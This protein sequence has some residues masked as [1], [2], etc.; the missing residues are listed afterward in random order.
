MTPG[1]DAA[2]APCAMPQDCRICDHFRVVI[3][4]SN[5][6]CSTLCDPVTQKETQWLGASCVELRVGTSPT[7]GGGGR[8]A[9]V[10]RRGGGRGHGRSV[11][12]P[13]PPPPPQ[14]PCTT[15]ARVCGREAESVRTRAVHVPSFLGLTHLPCMSLCPCTPCTSCSFPHQT[16]RS[17]SPSRFPTVANQDARHVRTPAGDGVAETHRSVGCGCGCGWRACASRGGLG[18]KC[19]VCCV[20][21]CAG[22]P[23]PPANCAV[24]PPSSLEPAEPHTEA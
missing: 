8:P 19:A 1:L 13:P 7:L 4:E 16:T 5:Q 15:S 12:W 2:R 10:R 3:A 21:L 23:S 20:L 17:R 18:G 6:Y 14:H 24:L 9:P 11:E 22:A